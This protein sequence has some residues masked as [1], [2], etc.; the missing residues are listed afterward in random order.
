MCSKKATFSFLLQMAEKSQIKRYDK[1]I[2]DSE[3]NNITTDYHALEISS[4][5]FDRI[6]RLVYQ[7]SG[8]D[9]HEGKE[10]LVKAR[11]LKRLRELNVPNFNQYLK[12]I[13]SDKSGTELRAMVDV[14]T[15]NKTNFFREA[16]HLDF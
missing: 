9:L 16:E 15:T 7:I 13:T 12:Y 2:M 11:L 14:L 4:Q 6:I 5:Q 10:E 8:I 1:K 3:S